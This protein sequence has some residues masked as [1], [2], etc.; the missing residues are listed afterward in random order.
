MPGGFTWVIRVAEHALL[1]AAPAWVGRCRFPF[2]ASFVRCEDIFERFIFFEEI[3]FI[4]V[5]PNGFDPFS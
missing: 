2:D 5:T 4:H 3:G 1:T